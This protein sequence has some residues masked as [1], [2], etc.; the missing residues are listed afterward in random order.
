VV[1]E[2]DI[3]ESLK[4]K[5]TAYIVRSLVQKAKANGGPDNISVIVVSTERDIIFDDDTVIED[6]IKIVYHSKT[7]KRKKR[8]RSFF[9]LLG[10]LILLLAV[11]IYW[12]VTTIC[13]SQHPLPGSDS[14]GENVTETR[15]K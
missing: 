8:K 11:I 1:P 4:V 2:S 9:L 12:L 5:S 14:G 3:A 7:K 6:T 10:L 15:E 13:A